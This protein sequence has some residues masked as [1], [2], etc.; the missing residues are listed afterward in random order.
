MRMLRATAYA[1]GLPALLVALWWALTRGRTSFW[2]PRPDELVHTF[3]EVWVGPRLVDDVLGSVLRL[4][5]GLAIAVVLGIALGLLI[6]SSPTWRA[7]SEPVLELFRAI[8]PPLLV[9][10]LMVII[11][12]GDA[13]K[14]AVIVF[15]CLWP[16]LLNTIEGV[17]SVDPVLTDTASAFGLRGPAR[18]LTLTLP[19]ASPHIFAGLRQALSIGLILMVISEMF[20]ARS[21]LGFTIVQFQRSFAIP[22]MWSGIVLLGLVGV[23][24][25]AAYALVEGRALRWYH[26]WKALERRD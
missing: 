14:I 15:G 25:A 4:F 9:P 21:G 26:G 20:A 10:I 23:G 19:A 3:V 16:I 18:T 17:R 2:V 24:L 11:G 6:G 13:M 22:E 1:L 7:A 8:P 12:I 5:A